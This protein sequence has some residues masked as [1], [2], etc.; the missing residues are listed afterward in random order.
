[1]KLLFL[2]DFFYDYD[3]ITDDIINISKYIKEN[4]YVT[5]L[6][7]E[8][9]KLVDNAKGL[10]KGTKLNFSDKYIEV[11]QLLN[12]KAVNIAN[13]H[14]MDYKDVG[15]KKIIEDLEKVN[16]GYFG[17]GL[18]LDK[19][20][21]PYSINFGEKEIAFLGMGWNMEECINAKKFNAGTCPLNFE[22][23]NRI[24]NQTECDIFIPI[25]HMGYEYEKFPQPLHLKKSRELIKNS[26]VKIVI[27]HHPH[28]VQAYENKIYYSL[29]NFYFGKMRASFYKNKKLSKDTSRGIGIVFDVNT[30]ETNILHFVFD[31]E[32]TTIKE[33]YNNDNMIDI[34]NINTMDYNSYFFRNN[35]F[36]NKKYVY[37]YGFVN[38]KVLNKLKYAKRN[39]YKKYLRNIKWPVIRFA[40]KIIRR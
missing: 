38:E 13:N 15:L 19:A 28:V 39:I 9:S 7:L 22:L 20:K 14:I 31:G 18:N 24:I 3:Y 2:G 11:L 32:N 34:T 23:L 33:D 5:I 26:K 25:L 17:A 40:K 16:I 8:G 37:N 35:N 36:Y 12:V 29:G 4:N 1:M 27:G 21:K 6:N 30:F 10:K